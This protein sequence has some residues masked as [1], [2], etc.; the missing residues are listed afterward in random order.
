MSSSTKSNEKIFEAIK[1][2]GNK[3]KRIRL[4]EGAYTDL[5]G[6][7][8]TWLK[9]VRSRNALVIVSIMKEKTK[10]LAEKIIKGFQAS[11]G[12]LDR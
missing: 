6:L 10:E 8:F 3:S 5:H 2:Q 11:N 7:I 4:H 9:T 1:A 12:C